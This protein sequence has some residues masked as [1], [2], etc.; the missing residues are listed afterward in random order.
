[1]ALAFA[2]GSAAMVRGAVGYNSGIRPQAGGFSTIDRASGPAV[3]AA[4]KLLFLKVTLAI[5]FSSEVG[6]GSRE[7]NASKQGSFTAP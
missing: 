6:T 7:E 5:A 3:K 4:A 2:F 1:M